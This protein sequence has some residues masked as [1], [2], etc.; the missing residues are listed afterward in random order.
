MPVQ[1]TSSQYNF[2]WFR[3]RFDMP[4]M[5]AAEE[6]GVRKT[7]FKKRCRQMGIRHWPFRKVRSLKRSIE[8]LEKM[9]DHATCT[10]K[11]MALYFSSRSKL[12]EIMNPESYASEASSTSESLSVEHLCFESYNQART[13][14]NEINGQASSRL[15]LELSDPIEVWVDSEVMAQS[16]LEGFL[17]S[18]PSNNG[19]SEGYE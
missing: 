19:G 11:H 13:M 7:A 5:D 16:K 3:D 9:K 2:E 10:E 8:E 6:M 1:R 14:Y 4:L 15:R 12:S 17:E 18:P